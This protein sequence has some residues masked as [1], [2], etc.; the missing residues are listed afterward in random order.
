MILAI[1]SAVPEIGEQSWIAPSAA[2]IGAATIGCEVGIWYNAV[3]RA[4]TTTITIGDRTNIQDGCVV[5]ADPGSPATIG[6]GVSVGHNATLH[7]CSIGDNVLIGMGA[8]VL[9]GAE[10][11]RDSLVA[12][13]ALIPE[14]MVVPPR[15]LVAGV[16]A[17]V[18]RELTEAEV[19]HIRANADGY[20]TARRTHAAVHAR[21]DAAV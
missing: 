10:I 1:D 6:S 18:R 12:A 15:S 17:K 5:H 19:D 2:V 13:G 7:G 11:G 14:K 9:N 3:I 16:P 4:D 8:T 21:A 20:L